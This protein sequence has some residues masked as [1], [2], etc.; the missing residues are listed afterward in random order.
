MSWT[1]L[2]PV[3]VIYH[4]IPLADAKHVVLSRASN[5]CWNTS[6]ETCATVKPTTDKPKGI[7]MTEEVE[8]PSLVAKTAKSEFR[9]RCHAAAWSSDYGGSIQV[10]RGHSRDYPGLL[11]LSATGPD[12]A[13]KAV[14]AVLYQ[15]DIPAEFVLSGDDGQ[16]MI[17]ARTEFNGKPVSYAAAIAKLA[18]GVVHLVAL[19]KIPGLMPNLSN[20]HLWAELSG[21][22][23]TTPLL[24][25]WTG[26]LKDT[27]TASGGIVVSDGVGATAG[28]LKS[29]P[30]ELDEILSQAVKDRCLRM[31]L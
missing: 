19:A 9:L 22:N 31:A 13:A 21:P 27:L 14:R 17:K 7:T 23:Y 10:F 26:W 4:A 8:L 25:S 29:T 20:D 1:S 12:T 16:T 24:R 6:L 11:L 28:V 18:H 15:P 3:S 2:I 5:R 30:A